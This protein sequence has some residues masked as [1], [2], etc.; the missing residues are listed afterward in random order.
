MDWGLKVMLGVGFI[1]NF[2]L[3]YS[4]AWFLV[5]KLATSKRINWFSRKMLPRV[6]LLVVVGSF[7]SF[8]TFALTIFII[9]PANLTV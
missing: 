5:D 9:W 1:L 3:G 4:I 6:L 8:L 2:I 7:V